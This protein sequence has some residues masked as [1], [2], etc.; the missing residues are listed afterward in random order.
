MKCR[1]KCASIH[2][3][4]YTTQMRDFIIDWINGERKT[5]FLDKKSITVKACQSSHNEYIN[6]IDSFF[7]KCDKVTINSSGKINGE[8]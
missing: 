5:L 1:K 3:K 6:S 7:R 4:S 2:V 8:E